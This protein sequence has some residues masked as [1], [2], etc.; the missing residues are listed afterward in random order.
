M[1]R[2]AHCQSSRNAIET[3][4]FVLIS[5]DGIVCLFPVSPEVMS[6]RNVH[7]HADY[8]RIVMG[9]LE[10]KK[11]MF[12]AFHPEP[13][14]I[15]LISKKLVVD[16]LHVVSTYS[17]VNWHNSLSIGENSFNSSV[18]C[19]K[20]MM[21]FELHHHYKPSVP[22]DLIADSCWPRANELVNSRQGH[23]VVK[24]LQYIFGVV[25]DELD[26]VLD[27]EMARAHLFEV[28]IDPVITTSV[29]VYQDTQDLP[30]TIANAN[31]IQYTV[32]YQYLGKNN[33]LQI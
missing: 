29:K 25:S 10:T 16:Y 32:V 23:R 3:P 5:I 4:V 15:L 1:S 17:R 11:V 9:I 7:L 14:V 19:M 30:I 33:I 22:Q 26:N 28:P 31:P 2:I 20:K 6:V 24:Q 13:Y 8:E 18:H 27:D 12:V 21:P